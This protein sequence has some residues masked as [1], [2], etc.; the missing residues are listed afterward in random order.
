MRICKRKNGKITHV[1][2]SLFWEFEVT[3]SHFAFPTLCQ[4]RSWIQIWELE[5]QLFTQNGPGNGFGN[6]QCRFSHFWPVPRYALNL[7]AVQYWYW[8][9]FPLQHR[10]VHI[11]RGTISFECLNVYCLRLCTHRY[12]HDMTG[13]SLVIHV[14]TEAGSSDWVIIVNNVVVLIE[15]SSSTSV[16]WLFIIYNCC[17]DKLSWLTSA[18]RTAI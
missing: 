13:F 15:S 3:K 1:D 2:N 5:F 14:E 11:G 17:S 12:A 9:W 4:K 8:T 16:F 7:Y 10:T 6:L 18:P